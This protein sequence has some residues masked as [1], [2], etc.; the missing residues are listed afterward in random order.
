MFREDLHEE[1]HEAIEDEIEQDQYLVFSVESQEFGI[2]AMR[3]QEITFL[4][5]VTRVP[6][7]PPHIEGIMNLRG[8]LVSVK[9]PEKASRRYGSIHW[10]RSPRC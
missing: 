9:N 6:N 1:I 7:A 10:N 4:S 3:I 8:K 2:Q 5:G